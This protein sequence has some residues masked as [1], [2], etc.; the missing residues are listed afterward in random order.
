MLTFGC[1]RTR[2][3]SWPTAFAGV[4]LALSVL[5]SAAAPSKARAQELE[6]GG[7]VGGMRAYNCVNRRG[8]TGDPFIR[9][10]P[11]PADA[12]ER[13]RASERE[14]RWVDRCRPV[15]RQDRY[16]VARYHYAMPGCGF[17]IGDY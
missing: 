9:I 15:I 3:G 10:V 12:A 17:G 14:R 5:V 6:S 7:C 16:G 13:A 2:R 4:A 11:P 8:P 1:A